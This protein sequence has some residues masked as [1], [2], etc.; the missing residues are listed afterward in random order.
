MAKFR[1]KPVVIDAVQW[2]GQNEF[3]IQNFIKN[4]NWTRR[5]I[6]QHNSHGRSQEV[7]FLRILS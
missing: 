5:R 7:S 3:E 1:K 6:R 4:G 2:N